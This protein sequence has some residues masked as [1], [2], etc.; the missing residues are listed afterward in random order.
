MKKL[1]YYTGMMIAVIILL[2]LIIVKSC[3]RP[4]EEPPIEQVVESEEYKITVYHSDIDVMAEMELE[5]YIKGVLAAEMPADF[6]LEALK[7]Q[8]VAA[9]TFAYGRMSGAYKSKQGVHDE[10]HICTDSTHCQA[11][12]SEENA[13]KKWNKLFA[14]R[15]WSKIEKAV[16]AT[17]GK[18]VVYEGKVANTLFHASSGGKT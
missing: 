3:S 12:V 1:V 2:P 13:K 6:S 7:A 10:A 14:S 9:R 11:W 5:E 18:I 16:N 4:V 15:N 17:K 8:A